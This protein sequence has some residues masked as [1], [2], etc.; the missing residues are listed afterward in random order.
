MTEERSGQVKWLNS[1]WDGSRAG[2]EADDESDDH[3]HGDVRQGRDLFLKHI[4]VFSFF[5]L[6]AAAMVGNAS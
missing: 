4:Q 2:G 1:P 3:G 5:G 6:D